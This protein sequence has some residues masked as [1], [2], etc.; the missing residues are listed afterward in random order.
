MLTSD[1]T[2]VGEPSE[3]Y[4]AEMGPALIFASQTMISLTADPPAEFAVNMS[5]ATSATELLE[6]EYDQSQVALHSKVS[7][8]GMDGRVLRTH[9]HRRYRAQRHVHAFVQ[10]DI[11]EGLDTATARPRPSCRPSD[12]GSREGRDL[13]TLRTGCATDSPLVKQELVVAFCCGVPLTTVFRRVLALRQR[14]RNREGDG[15]E[16]KEGQEVGFHGVSV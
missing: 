8:G 11:R 16:C 14:G 12:I 13:S 9:R 10:L 7:C 2:G 5:N 4:V 6:M 15:K 1:L 3:P